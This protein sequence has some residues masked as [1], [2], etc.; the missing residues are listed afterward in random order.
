[1][2]IVL[3]WSSSTLS[4]N[5]TFPMVQVLLTKG[6]NIFSL[7]CSNDLFIISFMFCFIESDCLARKRH[8]GLIRTFQKETNNLDSLPSHCALPITNKIVA[9]LISQHDQI[10]L[11]NGH[12]LH[13]GQWY[14]PSAVINDAWYCMVLLCIT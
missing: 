6:M 12:I 1:M 13:T 3:S 14:A 8:C 5:G 4:N 9:K 2:I 11:K 7:L 10:V